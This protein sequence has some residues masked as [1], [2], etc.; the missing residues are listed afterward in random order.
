MLRKMAMGLIL[1]L[2]PL[3]AWGGQKVRPDTGKG[4]LLVRPFSA[5]R[6]ADMGPLILYR[7]PGV[8]R[9]SE[10]ETSRLPRLDQIISIPEGELAMAVVSRKGEWLRLV[11]D[12]AGREGWLKME[13][14]WRYT[15]WETFLKGRSARL[16]P[17]LK[18]SYYSLRREGSDRSPQL[19]N[20]SRN[21]S[22]KII[23]VKG[24]WMLALVDLTS[25]GWLRW[26]DSDGRFLI[27][28]T[29]QID[30]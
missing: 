5:E 22:L 7:E 10:F 28:L 20:L 9:I 14:Y 21:K 24:D 29:E 12:E 6:Q 1:L 13:R 15:P 23:E 4:I 30:R 18:N 16:L 3:V 25:L 17:G 11:Y 8:A 26:R 19:E 2:S 27:S